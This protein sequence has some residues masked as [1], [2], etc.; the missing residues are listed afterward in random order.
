MELDTIWWQSVNHMEPYSRDKI[1]NFFHLIL[2]Y[3]RDQKLDFYNFISFILYVSLYQYGKKITLFCMYEYVCNYWSDLRH[4]HS[5]TDLGIE[6]VHVRNTIAW[7]NSAWVGLEETKRQ[8]F[9]PCITLVSEEWVRVDHE[10]WP[11]CTVELQQ[12]SQCVTEPRIEHCRWRWIRG[13]QHCHR[14]H[15]WYFYFPT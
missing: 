6:H 3:H 13:C 14:V 8:R 5:F 11:I 10:R 9:R 2:Y 15:R 12:W 7:V 4:A 1:L